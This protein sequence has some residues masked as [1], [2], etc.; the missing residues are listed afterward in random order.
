[1][2]STYIAWSIEVYSMPNYLLMKCWQLAESFSVNVY[3]ISSNKN[4]FTV[5]VYD[6]NDKYK[7]NE[8]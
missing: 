1:M 3:Y 8:L 5:L 2:W 7:W 6:N 4:V